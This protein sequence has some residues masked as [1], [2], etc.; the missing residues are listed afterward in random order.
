MEVKIKMRKIIVLSGL[1]LLI[2]GCALVAVNRVTSADKR[3][4]F[5]EGMTFSEVE[6][7][8]G[9]G[10]S[11]FDDGYSEEVVGGSVYKTWSIHGKAVTPINTDRI[12]EFKFKDDKLVSWSWTR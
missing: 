2:S 3:G 6:K 5:H 4:E 11:S 1:M 10:V 8:A 7:I 9:R 12:Y